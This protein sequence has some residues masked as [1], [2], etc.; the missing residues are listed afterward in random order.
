MYLGQEIWI[1][2]SFYS[3][4]HLQSPW[5]KFELTLPKKCQYIKYINLLDLGE[6]SAAQMNNRCQRYSR[7]LWGKKN[8]SSYVYACVRRCVR[9]C[10]R[11]VKDVQIS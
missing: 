9:A 10:M 1:F 7:H 6:E 3:I 2:P 4:S 5:C 8:N 11:W